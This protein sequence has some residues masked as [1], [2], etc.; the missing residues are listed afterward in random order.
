MDN[1]NYTYTS[2]LKG[3]HDLFNGQPDTFRRTLGAMMS[4]RQQALDMM[5]GTNLPGPIGPSFEYQ[6]VNPG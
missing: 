2:L 3:L 5:A 6:P 1:F 4:L